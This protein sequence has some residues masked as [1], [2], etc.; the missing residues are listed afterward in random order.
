MKV[1]SGIIVLV[2]LVA[3][4]LIYYHN[5]Q[6]HRS[7][8]ELKNSEERQFREAAIKERELINQVL[9]E[10]YKADM[11]SYRILIKR[12]EME[13]KHVKELEEKIKSREGAEK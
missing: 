6:L 2:L 1:I 8:V 13:K 4:F 11:A 12:V 5:F 9:S 10:K 3:C 7:L